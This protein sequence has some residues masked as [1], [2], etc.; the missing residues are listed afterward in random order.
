MAFI[1]DSDN[2]VTNPPGWDAIEPTDI[3]NSADS[4]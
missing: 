1:A 3:E 2:P 4:H